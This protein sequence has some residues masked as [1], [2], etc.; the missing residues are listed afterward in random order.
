MHEENFLFSSVGV[1]ASE[2]VQ[3]GG[4]IIFIN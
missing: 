1:G 3:V 4:L 2:I